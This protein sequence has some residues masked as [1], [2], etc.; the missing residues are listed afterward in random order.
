MIKFNPQERF[1][2]VEGNI[3]CVSIGTQM[4]CAGI[5]AIAAEI[6]EVSNQAL[7]CSV[8]ARE[9]ESTEYEKFGNSKQ[10]I[11]EGV[12]EQFQQENISGGYEFILV[13]MLYHP[14]DNN[15]LMSKIAGR[16]F[17]KAWLAKDHSV[18]RNMSILRE[19]DTLNVCPSCGKNSCAYIVYGL[20]NSAVISDDLKSGTAV[21]GGSV[22]IEGAPMWRCNSCGH[23]W[24]ESEES[25]LSKQ[26][27]L[28][29]EEEFLKKEAEAI[30]R[31]VMNAQQNQHGAIRC[32][33][34]NIVF[35]I[36]SKMSFSENIHLT[37]RTRLNI[38]PYSIKLDES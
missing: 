28:K 14:V 31:G 37:C 19:I 7:L 25:L 12:L 5:S 33:Y 16:Y 13:S 9:S 1:K 30:N 35:R 2:H 22:I 4:N 32:P 11:F 10:S 3:Y 18:V 34:C 24:G 6:R 38:L 20:P 27:A 36:T 29:A 21:L 15:L 23:E 8:A 17:V 26:H